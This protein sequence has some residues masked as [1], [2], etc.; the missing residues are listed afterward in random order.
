MKLESAWGKL[1]ILFQPVASRST[2][3]A[4]FLTQNLLLRDAG[5]KFRAFTID[6]GFRA[7]I[8][9][10]P[11]FAHLSYISKNAMFFLCALRAHHCSFTNTLFTSHFP[12]PHHVKMCSNH[13][14]A[15]A[16][17]T[18]LRHSCGQIRPER[19]GEWE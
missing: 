6:P 7:F 18:V 5:L 17:A 3:S 1:Q 16:G 13:C 10:A 12:Q 4:Q 19:L 9:H 15:L 14:L 8:P 2:V 11:N